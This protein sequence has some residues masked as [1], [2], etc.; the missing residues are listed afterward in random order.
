MTGESGLRTIGELARLTGLTVKTIRFWSDAGL[1]PPDG[2][3][4]TGYRLYGEAALVRLGLVRTLRDLGVDVATIRRVL[5][6]EASVAE[7]AGAHAAALDVRIRELQR[8]R[9]VLHRVAG[10][11]TVTAEEIELMHRLAQLSDAERRRLVSDFI[12]ETFAGLD[13]GPDFLPM[14]RRAMPDL[15]DEPA[16]EQVD[17]WV[18][19][20]EL[21]QDP[22][23]R[24][25]VRR[26]AID[27]TRAIGE[28]G[29][30][31][32]EVQEAMVALMRD[33]VEPAAEAGIPPGSSEAR[34]I[35]EEVAA[36][37]ARHTGRP[38]GPEF[39]AWLADRLEASSD[40]RY[41][42]YWQLL[43]VINGWEQTSGLTAAARWLLV[44]LRAG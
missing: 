27:Q 2:R 30:P 31:S 32:P 35:V 13:L 9:A 36:A 43:A 11:G 4:P 14:L 21:T 25:S 23:F 24:A 3:T 28:A 22:D 1:V 44:G 39:R 34:P 20:A 17:A 41:E 33:R 8:Q 19:L 38:D 40:S 18:E 15:P 16:Q 5:K 29:Q 12:D 10:K 6:R 26:A 37:W 7:V 42:R